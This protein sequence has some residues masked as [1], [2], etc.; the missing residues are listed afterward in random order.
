MA[1]SQ[2]VA[3]P[4]V[5]T[6]KVH[7]FSAKSLA[8]LGLVVLTTARAVVIS[9]R[10]GS[11]GQ[12]AT[13]LELIVLVL[14]AT[15]LFVRPHPR[16]PASL[17]VALLGLIAV[18]AFDILWQQLPLSV[19][20]V[21]VNAYLRYFLLAFI[22]Y[23]LSLDDA[24]MEAVLKVLAP[25]FIGLSL[26][27]IVQFVTGHAE[28]FFLN[29][30]VPPPMRG[31]IRQGV[32]I[33]D[34]PDGWALFC[35]A[36]FFIYLARRTRSSLFFLTSILLALAVG[37]TLTR[38]C[39]AALLALLILYLLKQRRARWRAAAL[40]LI[41]AV[42]GVLYGGQ[43]KSQFSDLRFYSVGEAPRVAYLREGVRI[44]LSKPLYT[45]T[46]V[47]YNRFGRAAPYAIDDPRTNPINGMVTT[48]ATTDSIIASLLPEFGVVGLLL[49]LG[50]FVVVL[51]QGTHWA[52]NNP[53]ARGYVYGMVFV[54]LSSLSASDGFFGAYAAVFWVAAGLILVASQ[55]E[56]G[57][58][59]APPPRRWS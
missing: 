39:I 20:Y 10:W 3:L 18:D 54:L 17:T 35:G 27:T 13:R 32:G 28:Q 59:T 57:F 52:K 16:A 56:S 14:A 49:L 11:L 50:F 53:A 21:G 47:G 24:D 55:R 15:Y 5:A 25:V 1:G 12:Q 30:S 26:L 46:G 42:L 31:G 23:A 41:I 36:W 4:S 48:L 44:F 19:L 37:A 22:V 38:W 45:L 51:R 8:L 43:I 9:P 2:A 58:S 40:V 29:P 33:F 7:V 6:P 34:W